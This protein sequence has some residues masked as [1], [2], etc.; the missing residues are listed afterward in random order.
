MQFWE[1]KI[2]PNEKRK[3]ETSSEISFYIRKNVCNFEIKIII[4]F[5]C[6]TLSPTVQAACA[7]HKQYTQ[8]FQTQSSAKSYWW[9]VLHR[10]G[11]HL[12]CIELI[13]SN[14]LKYQSTAMLT[15]IA[16]RHQAMV[17]F[18]LY[19]RAFPYR[20]WSESGFAKCFSFR[21]YVFAFCM[22]RPLFLI[23]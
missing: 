22:G 16:F 2:P 10:N 9:A 15:K 13:N 20:K 5:T 4:W 23:I 8:D 6:V 19:V 21:F 14:V 3:I 11:W 17:T 18:L 12:S 1:V 7:W